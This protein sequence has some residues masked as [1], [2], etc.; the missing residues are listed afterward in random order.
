MRIGL[1]VF[2]IYCQTT[3]SASLKNSVHMHIFTY[4][5]T[6]ITHQNNMQQSHTLS[7]ADIKNA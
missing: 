3:G 5:Y 6:V 1:G 4:W 7:K 2:E